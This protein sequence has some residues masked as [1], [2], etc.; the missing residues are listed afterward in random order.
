MHV[1]MAQRV[2]V[3]VVLVISF[4]VNGELKLHT[5]RA[6]ATTHTRLCSPTEFY[7]TVCCCQL[8]CYYYTTTLYSNVTHGV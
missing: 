8:L 2:H 4:D 6:L 5:T 3:V 1:D 7:V